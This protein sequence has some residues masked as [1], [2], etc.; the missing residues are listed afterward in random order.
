MNDVKNTL[1]AVQLSTLAGRSQHAFVRGNRASEIV[2]YGLAAIALLF[3]A[4]LF[5]IIS[6]LIKLM[7]QGPI[8]Y[9]GLRVGKDGRI[10]TMYTFPTQQLGAEEGIGARP[11]TKH[12]VYDTRLGKFLKRTKLDALPQLLN[13]LKGDMNLVGPRPIRPLFFEKLCRDLPRYPM[14]FAV[15]PGITSLA[16]VQ[17]WYCPASPSP[18]PNAPVSRRTGDPL[19]G[20]TAE[21]HTHRRWH[22]AV[23][24]LALATEL[25]YPERLG[26]SMPYEGL[27]GSQ[28]LVKP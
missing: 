25:R 27:G 11:L 15:K 6:L 20:E 3:T 24:C 13:V 17:D 23:S 4:P 28:R 26:C 7:S 10:F 14:R 12:A 21:L 16:Q 9:R 5:L 19:G 1:L 2:Q 22:F 8:F 18:R